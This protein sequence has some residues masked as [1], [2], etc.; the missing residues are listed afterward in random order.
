MVAWAS[1]CLMPAVT[2]DRTSSLTGRL[3]LETLAG[4][5][6]GILQEG[7]WC[8]ERRE[9]ALSP[10]CADDPCEGAR[11]LGIRRGRDLSCCWEAPKEGGRPGLQ[12]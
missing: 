2:S 10:A 5:K 12:G 1:A 3:L 11:T 6:V 9:S 8:E 4:A 7:A